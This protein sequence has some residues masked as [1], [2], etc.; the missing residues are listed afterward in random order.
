VYVRILLQ[1]ASKCRI[2]HIYEDF[3]PAFIGF[4]P[5][6][7]RT[8]LNIDFVGL[9][10]DHKRKV[11]DVLIGQIF[12]DDFEILRWLRECA[13]EEWREGGQPVFEAGCR[14]S[15]REMR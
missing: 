11:F 4:D 2:E 6:E 7:T 15:G 1:L 12:R 14:V 13:A 8:P 10:I 5:R 3:V 9:H